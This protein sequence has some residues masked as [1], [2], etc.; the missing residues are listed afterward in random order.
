MGQKV[1][2]NRWRMGENDLWADSNWMPKK[3]CYANLIGE[4]RKI[5]NY[6][7]TN[8]ALMQNHS[9]S[10]FELESMI[11][12]EREVYVGLLIEHLE[13]QRKEEAKYKNK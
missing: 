12:W 5:R 7:K 2:P 10:L 11:P 4:D 9:W 8:F 3:G 6:F 13:E 1:D